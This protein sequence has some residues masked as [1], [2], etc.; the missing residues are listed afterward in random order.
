MA[1]TANLFVSAGRTTTQV[2][3]TQ[4]GHILEDISHSVEGGLCANVVRNGTMK[5]DDSTPPAHWSL[6]TSGGSTGAIS[7]DTASPL[8]AANRSSLRLDIGMNGAG[9]RVG[10]A[11]SGFGGIGVRPNT[12][13]SVAFWTR[14]T[15]G[16]TGTLTVTLESDTGTVL[17]AADAGNPTTSW[18]KITRTLTTGASVPSSNANR[19][20]IAA[21]AHGNGQSVWFT[22]VQ[23]TI[24]GTNGIREDLARLLADTGPGFF[25]IP[26]GNYLEGNTLPTRFA[27]KNTVGPV[28]NRPGHQNDAWG[29]W[30]TDQFGLLDYLQL[31]E[32]AGAEPLLAVFAGYTLNGTAVAQRA[33]EPYIKEALDEIEYAIGGTDT[34]WGAQRAAHGHPAPFPVRYVEIGNE[35]I[36]DQSGSYDR[37]RFPAFYDRIKARY[38]HLRIVATAPVTSRPADVLD[39]HFYD[40]DHAQFALLADR[41]APVDRNGPQILIGEYG[42]LD[43]SPVN[44]TGTLGGALAEAAF[45]TGT[46]RNADLVIGA[47]YAPALASLGMRN[48]PANM[49]GFDPA[50]SYCSPSYYV[51]KL[52]GESAGDHVVPS[53]LNGADDSVRHVATRTA[54]G[55]VFITVVNPTPASVPA[56]IVV[57]GT[58]GVAATAKATTL[59]GAPAARNTIDA[60]RTVVPLTDIITAG[61]TFDHTFPASSLVVLQLSTTG[62]AVPALPGSRTVSLRATTPGFTGHSLRHQ[63]WLGFIS[64]VTASS[65]NLDKRDATFR[66]VE[67]LADDAAYSFES[68]NYPGHYLRHSLFRVRLDPWLDTSLFAA[69]ATFHAVD[70]NNGEGISL[71]SH[72]YSDRFLRHYG[73]EVWIAS[74][75]GPNPYDNPANWPADTTWRLTSPWWRS[76]V[77]IASGYHSLRA[78]TSGFTGHSLRHQSWLGFI[79][80]VTAS[81]SDLDRKDATFNVVTGLADGSCY[82]FE[83]RNYPGYYLR[84]SQFRVRLDKWVDSSLFAADATFCALRGNYGPGVS[85]RSYNYPTRFLRHYAGE[86]WIASKG[87]PNPYDNP[88]IWPA[89]TTWQVIDPW[90]P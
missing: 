60:P 42:V 28:E 3:P 12:S 58:A 45:L 30:S 2:N 83:S 72:N 66:V 87:G 67:G 38:P 11:N 8:N 63:S 80:P 14:A 24:K 41:Y 23:C 62:P 1:P 10:A 50:S 44:P 69:D 33:L 53:S 15:P 82:S 29:Y 40:A 65:S 52:F 71:R 49:I 34:T 78:T 4:F 90:A 89:D 36:F 73:G 27:W 77:D 22:V 76:E 25:R 19:F 20:V 43:T 88:A 54:D 7:T 21:N 84:H 26:G 48:W 18:R 17:A 13:H 57:T 79:S 81:S 31:A 46:V 39:E 9:Q 55:T 70:G 85:F 75:G 56:H 61:P 35:D 51:L 5:E 47:A 6:V 86:I 37:Y 74:M 32:H 59:T 64:P 16:F 68:L